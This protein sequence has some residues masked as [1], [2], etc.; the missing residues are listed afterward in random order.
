[1]LNLNGYAYNVASTLNELNEL[2]LATF[3]EI[4]KDI[5]QLATDAGLSVEWKKAEF[6]ALSQHN[7]TL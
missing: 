5:K 2:K 3:K 1:M 7:V 6:W 4:T